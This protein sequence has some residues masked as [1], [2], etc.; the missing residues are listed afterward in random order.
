MQLPQGFTD[1]H[2]AAKL[3]EA[4]I[5]GKP[6]KTKTAEDGI[7]PR[8]ASKLLNTALDKLRE[9]IEVELDVSNGVDLAS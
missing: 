7:T 6:G 2:L 5:R 3:S 1:I 9:L 4:G 8:G